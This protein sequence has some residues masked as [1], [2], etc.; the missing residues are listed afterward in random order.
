MLNPSAHALAVNFTPELPKF[1]L[2]LLSGPEVL[3]D[4]DQVVPG[5]ERRQIELGASVI[6]IGEGCPYLTFHS[7]ELA[8]LEMI[9]VVEPL[10]HS[11]VFLHFRSNLASSLSLSS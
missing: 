1:P 10:P 11:F 8:G 9:P 7:P 3:C 5:F 2:F 6:Q 4:C